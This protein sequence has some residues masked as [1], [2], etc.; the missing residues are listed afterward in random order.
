[1]SILSSFTFGCNSG[2]ISPLHFTHPIQFNETIQSRWLSAFHSSM[3]QIGLAG[4]RFSL[5]VPSILYS[6]SFA[7][8]LCCLAIEAKLPFWMAVLAP[9]VVISVAGYGFFDLSYPPG[10]SLRIDHVSR[11]RGGETGFFH[12]TI[13]LF[14]GHRTSGFSFSIAAVLFLYLTVFLKGQTL[15]GNMVI[16]GLIGLV[17]ALHSQAFIGLSVFAFI[18][19]LTRIKR[20][21]VYF[22]IGYFVSLSVHI[23]RLIPMLRKVTFDPL[24][25]V[26]IQKG[27]LFPA[28]EYC[29]DWLGLFP[30][31]ALIC[32]LFLCYKHEQPL[33]LTAIITFSMSTQISLKNPKR[34][35]SFMF[36]FSVLP[37]CAV[38]FL[39]FLYRFAT[40]RKISEELRGFF[41]CAAVA[42]FIL[43]VGSSVAGV[44]I[45]IWQ[46][47]KVW[48]EDDLNLAVWIRRNVP[49]NAVFLGI[50]REMSAVSALAGRISFVAPYETAFEL[51]LNQTI[52][53]GKVRE[54][55][56]IEDNQGEFVEVGYLVR[57]ENGRGLCGEIKLSERRWKVVGVI[58]VYTVYEQGGEKTV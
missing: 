49:K 55:C 57:I 53:N 25:S 7:V 6:I 17:P 10:Q 42:L 13:H 20:E 36:Y 9:I 21:T 35:D 5:V 51:G 24:W 15:R 44:R 31:V 27:H 37:F 41:S 38:Y 56:E 28:L 16:G 30:L 1:M 40:H 4:I 29:F 43:T 14:L 54:Y 8:L 11:R 47:E 18:A 32:P 2:F 50:E 26:Y 34:F 52:V 3:L 33:L 58:G 45:Q 12:P 39:A 22:L 23:T 46:S 19:F 48:I